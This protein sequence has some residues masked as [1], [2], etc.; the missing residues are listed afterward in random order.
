MPHCAIQCTLRFDAMV[1]PASANRSTPGSDASYGIPAHVA[2]GI[3]VK[4]LDGRC[5]HARLWIFWPA[6]NQWNLVAA[7]QGLSMSVPPQIPVVAQEDDQSV[8]SI[9]FSAKH[10]ALFPLGHPQMTPMRGTL[11]C[12]FAVSRGVQLACFGS[13]RLLAGTG[14]FFKA[15]PPDWHDNPFCGEG[16]NT[17]GAKKGV[18][19][20][21][22]PPKKGSTRLRKFVKLVFGDLCNRR[23]YS[24][25]SPKT[26]NRAPELPSTN[27]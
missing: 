21:N 20:E 23:R 1:V 7:E 18:R 14:S 25:S 11:E 24:M 26:T 12:Y 10:P 5:T 17:A 13:Q 9:H 4:Q 15:P 2:R 6:N 8:L 19:T 22:P 16:R 27:G 3:H